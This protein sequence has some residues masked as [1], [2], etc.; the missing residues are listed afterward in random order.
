[1][2]NLSTV[3]QGYTR[4]AAAFIAYALSSDVKWI[5]FSAFIKD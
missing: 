3:N 5:A 2:I 4:W 1:V